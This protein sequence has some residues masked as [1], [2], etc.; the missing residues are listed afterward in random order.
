MKKQAKL[1]LADMVLLAIYRT[2][3]GTNKRVPF[4]E[5]VLQAWKDFP[6][7]FS[8]QNHPEYPDSAVVYQQLYAVLTAKRWIVSLRKK[9]VRLTEKGIERAQIIAENPATQSARIAIVPGH[10]NRDEQEFIDYAFRSRA[11]RTWKASGGDSLIDYDARVFLQFST[12]TPLRERKRRLAN[13]TEAIEKAI[14]LGVPDANSLQSLLLYMIRKF[15][16][17]FEEVK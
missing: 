10:L 2:S 1:G 6:N 9:V 5:I 13:A 8:L 4:E 14:S 15:P 7:Q 16:T 11:F 17:L 12:G 3:R